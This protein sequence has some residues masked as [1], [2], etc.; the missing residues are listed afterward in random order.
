MEIKHQYQ[1]TPCPSMQRLTEVSVTYVHRI[2]QFQNGLTRFTKLP[3]N[4]DSTGE[5][6]I[7]LNLTFY[8]VTNFS[9]HTTPLTTVVYRTVSLSKP[10]TQKATLAQSIVTADRCEPSS[11]LSIYLCMLSIRLTWCFLIWICFVLD[12]TAFNHIAGHIRTMPA[13]NRGL[14]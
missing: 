7:F 9:H 8:T 3:A 13:C 11:M 6:M 12:V 14:C 2:N 4:S 10:Y 5:K 1:V